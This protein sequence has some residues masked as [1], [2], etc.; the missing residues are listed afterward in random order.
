MSGDVVEKFTGAPPGA[1]GNL[2]QRSVIVGVGPPFTSADLRAGRL[3][4]V[5]PEPCNGASSRKCRPNGSRAS[6]GCDAGA[7]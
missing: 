2:P 1:G 4:A 6:C 7:E 3:A 5:E